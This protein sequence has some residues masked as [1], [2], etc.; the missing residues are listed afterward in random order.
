MQAFPKDSANNAIGGSG[1]VNKVYDPSQFMGHN[2]NEAFTDYS[3]SGAD[4]SNYG[5][6]DAKPSQ[7]APPAPFN[8]TARVD[9]I[10]GDESL[11]LGTSTFLEGT[12]ASR[13]AIQRRESESEVVQVRPP[14][15]Q[16]KKS[17]VQKI[18]GING[19]R[20]NGASGRVISPEPR[21]E[22]GSAVTANSPR[23]LSAGGLGK[24]DQRSN[25]FFNEYDAAYDQKGRSIAVAQEER[26]SVVRRDTAEERRSTNLERRITADNT[27]P[28][29]TK[30]TGGFLSRV[31]SL[32]GGK[33]SRP[34][35][36]EA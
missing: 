20:P 34:E 21:Y 19:P 23:A 14:G 36:I 9:P 3:K 16:R 17:L 15:L 18:R 28:D 6:Y 30:A 8:P 35:R 29:P 25:P 10:H 26:L 4:A 31:K 12:P 22:I 32:K 24:M 11:G 27:Q 5:A 33:R 7:P 2:N 13:R 1:P